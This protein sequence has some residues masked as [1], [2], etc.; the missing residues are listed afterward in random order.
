MC[1]REGFL[2]DDVL[3]VD[4][5]TT[6]LGSTP[7]FLIG[8]MG[9]EGGGLVVRQYFARNYAE[10]PAV[11]RLFLDLLRRKPLLVSFNGKSF[12]MPYVRVR[13]AANGLPYVEPANHFDLLHVS[14]RIWRGYLP[15]C[16]LQTLERHVCGRTR[17][18]DIPGADIPQAYHD[19]VRTG[20]ARQMGECLRHNRLDLITLADLM[21][22][23][24]A[25]D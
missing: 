18:G 20:D 21:V 19:F 8:T 17:T 25:P 22:R 24:P 15:D 3:F 11:V 2:P 4:L 9:W 5:E 12:D 6:G 13:A 14:R 10:E 16:R 23:L 1:G 7:L